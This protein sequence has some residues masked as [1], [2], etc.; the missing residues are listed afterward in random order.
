[1]LLA[2]PLMLRDIVKTIVSDQPDMEVVGELGLDDDL[3]NAAVE[4]GADFVITSFEETGLH[5]S[6]TR[7]LDA[8]SR[9]KVLAIG[10]DGRQA[11]LYELRP[12]RYAVGEL[13]PDVLA[14]VIRK[15]TT[16]RLRLVG[17]RKGGG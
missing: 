5:P 17:P 14:A 4:T 8:R 1:V 3:S 12:R 10:G 2:M 6:C 16:P 7:L 13:S 15:N 11:F 9:V